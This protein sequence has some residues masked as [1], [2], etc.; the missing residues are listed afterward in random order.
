MRDRKFVLKSIPCSI[1]LALSISVAL[2]PPASADT[3][4]VLLGK[5]SGVADVDQQQAQ[6]ERRVRDAMSVGRL[7]RHVGQ[8]FL[9]DLENVAE[10]EASYRASHGKLSLWERLKLLFELDGLSRKLE[11][12]LQDRAIADSDVDERVNELKERVENAKRDHRLTGQEAQGFLYELSGSEDLLDSYRKKG[13]SLSDEEVLQLSLSLDRLSARLESTMHERQIELP[14]VSHAQEELENRLSTGIKDKRISDGEAEALRKEFN[15]LVDREK[16]LKKLDRPLTAEETL[17]LASDLEKLSNRLDMKLRDQVSLTRDREEKKAHI[18]HRIADGVISGRLTLPEADYLK[19]LLYR[20]DEQERTYKTE[21]SS[22]SDEEEKALLL[23]VE[24]LAGKVERRLYDTRHHWEGISKALDS[25]D[26]RLEA[27]KEA[28][29]LDSDRARNLTRELSR[30]HTNW[31]ALQS[32]QTSAAAGDAAFPLRDSLYLVSDLQR[33]NR[34]MAEELSDRS[35]VV[36][37]LASLKAA[38]DKRIAYGIVVGKLTVQEAANAIDELDKI[39]RK[40]VGY[41]ASESDLSDKEKLSLAREVERL[42]AVLERRIHDTGETAP[43]LAAQKSYILDRLEEAVIS[44]EITETE[45]EDLS[46]DLKQIEQ[47]EDSYKGPGKVMRAKEALTV[48]KMIAALKASISQE[49]ADAEIKQS[50]IKQRKRDIERKISAG[51]TTGRLVKDEAAELRDELAKI[52]QLESKYETDGGMSI[53]EAAVVAYRL[54]K[55]A[56]ELEQKKHDTRAT[57]PDIA[58]LQA[59]LEEQLASAISEGNLTL[60]VV[61]KFKKRLDH[62]ARLEMSLRFSGEG[63][64]Y[65]ESRM[66]SAEVDKL[67][68]DIDTALA[69][70]SAAGVGITKRID[71]TS[72][73]IVSGVANKKLS[74]D[75]ANGLKGELDRI[76]NAKIAFAHSGGGFT[77]DEAETLVRD[78]DRLNSEIDMRLK[79]QTFAWRDLDQRQTSLEYK[80]KAHIRTGRLRGSDAARMQAEL[81]KIKRAKAAFS[82]TDGGLNFFERVALGKALDKFDDM[83]KKR[84]SN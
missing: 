50:D 27:A 73:R 79:G 55:L 21:R 82:M 38:L 12:S 76:R 62:I 28:G 61:E 44:G 36:P 83:L 63:L 43:S 25:T 81:D 4:S 49:L 9:L 10:L 19:R 11:T 32:I 1:A 45:S 84:V 31:K 33:L 37:D 30:I 6:I 29:R 58:G 54:E 13:T 34:Q 18:G 65:A 26:R 75:G 46:E 70:K 52:G 39:E 66:L 2:M 59:D 7:S 22:L 5:V 41:Q 51:V 47:L 68:F 60:A 14:E 16:V 40:E 24:K 53:T 48:A 57:V 67:A 56:A 20:I 17:A 23:A 78:L 69:R 8:E 71:D 77:L 3:M 64:S 42:S 80:L 74:S 72:E 15:V 35:L